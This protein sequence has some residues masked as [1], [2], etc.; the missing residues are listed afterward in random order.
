M[1]SISRYTL[2]PTSAS[3]KQL[4]GALPSTDL[5][6][7]IATVAI[8]LVD[9][10]STAVLSPESTAKFLDIGLSTLWDKLNPKSRYHDPDLKPPLELGDRNRRF[11]IAELLAYLN[12]KAAKRDKAVHS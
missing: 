1:Q 9:D 8:L 11:L 12:L 5:G 10:C 6:N 4:A 2:T 7:T 3:N